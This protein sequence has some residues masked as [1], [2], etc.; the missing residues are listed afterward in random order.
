MDA[1]LCS[2]VASANIDEMFHEVSRLLK[3]GGYFIVVSSGSDE[4]RRFFFEVDSFDWRLHETLRIDRL[5]VRGTFYYVY[6]AEK[7]LEVEVD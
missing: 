3:P 6:I 7:N 2:D 1:Q 4:I 5:P